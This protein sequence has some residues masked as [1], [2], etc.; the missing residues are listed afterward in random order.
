MTPVCG[1]G[2]LSVDGYAFN[3]WTVDVGKGRKEGERGWHTASWSGACIPCCLTQLVAALAQVIGTAM[4]YNRTLQ[5]F[6]IN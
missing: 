4:Y 6:R 2:C 3:G 5:G 1:T